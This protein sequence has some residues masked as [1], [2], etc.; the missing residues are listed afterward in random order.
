MTESP[1]KPTLYTIYH[2][3]NYFETEG[4]RSKEGEKGKSQG[5]GMIANGITFTLY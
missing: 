2:V 5:L 3:N 4:E 1:P